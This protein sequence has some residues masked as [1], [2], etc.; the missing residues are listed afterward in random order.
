MPDTP[1]TPMVLDSDIALAEKWFRSSPGDLVPRKA[2][3][4]KM[5]AEIAAAREAWGVPREEFQAV[6]P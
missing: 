3:I 4:A 5:A 6:Q 2:A 1:P